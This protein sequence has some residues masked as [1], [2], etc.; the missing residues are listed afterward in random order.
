M[1]RLRQEGGSTS[2]LALGVMVVLLIMVTGVVPLTTNGLGLAK[3]NSDQMAARMA[4]E[5]GIKRAAAELNEEVRD[6]R[7]LEQTLYL[8]NGSTAQYSVA[9]TPKPD[10]NKKIAAYTVT[11]V[12]KNGKMEQTVT[13]TIA[14]P[15]VITGPFAYAAYAG[16]SMQLD[17]GATVVGSVNALGGVVNNAGAKVDKQAWD[18]ALKPDF[19]SGGAFGPQ[20]Y[21][22]A[23][24]FSASHTLLDQA[25]YY[26][27]TGE[28]PLMI[29]DNTVFTVSSPAKKVTIY[30]DGNLNLGKNVRFN[31]EAKV[32]FFISGTANFGEN[33]GV[34]SKAKT[35]IVTAGS[36]FSSYGGYYDGAVLANG[37]LHMTNGCRVNYNLDLIM[38]MV[39]DK[40]PLTM[41]AATINW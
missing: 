6:W 11:A 22:T 12:G 27:K 31:D 25:V 36:T 10:D 28:T 15:A 20:K 5:A 14:I 33:Y 16:G 17:A 40:V 19:S 32:L 24:A 41:G 13:A 1:K 39:G 26:C 29:P 8:Y 23:P 21:N 34:G 4:A 35:L 18:I 9:I 38:D 2:I 7:W 30:I 3:N 37:S